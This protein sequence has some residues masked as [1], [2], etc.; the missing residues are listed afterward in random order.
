MKI[1]GYRT[2]RKK[3]KWVDTEGLNLIFCRLLKGKMQGKERS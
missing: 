2:S 3:G 1:G